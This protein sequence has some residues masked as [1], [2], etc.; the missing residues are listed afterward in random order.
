MAPRGHFTTGSLSAFLFLGI[1]RGTF[2]VVMYCAV[3]SYNSPSLVF[4]LRTPGTVA[5]YIVYMTFLSSTNSEH[6]EN[7][8]NNFKSVRNLWKFAV[9]GFVQLAAPYIL[10]MYGLKVLNPITAGVFM[11]AAPWFSILLE[12]LPCGRST[13]QVSASK[14]GA[15]VIGSI[16]I[17]LVSA[18]GIGL[19]V[20][21]PKSCLPNGTTV[22]M[23][24][25]DNTTVSPSVNEENM[26]KCTPF[27]AVELAGSLLAL[28]GGSVMWSMS[29]IFWRSKR[30]NIHYV[31]GG[32]GNNI[33]G[34]I[35]ALGFFFIMQKHEDYD[36]INW[37]DG[38]AVFSIIFLTLISGWLAALLVDYMMNEVG[39]VVTN[40]VLCMV[41]IV[42][43]F[44][45]WIF[46]REFKMLDVGY[47]I[48]EVVGIVLVLVGL[49]I[50]SLEPENL[51][52][53][54]G[55]PLLSDK[56]QSWDS[57]QFYENV[58][59]VDDGTTS[60]EEVRTPNYLQQSKSFPPLVKITDQDH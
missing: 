32:I 55:R 24:I 23:N 50:S 57:T 11:T 39:A 1:I 35:F 44:E 10:F 20:K 8:R 12:R 14:L 33:F 48:S 18:S 36:Q 27:S 25:S 52:S 29:S 56:E 60:D 46:V 59:I 3:H 2:P 34:G 38:K 26:S 15:I 5:L 28:L 53:V 43:W 21:N 42:V 30:G 54:L 22:P 37:G 19:A 41:P 45:D 47:I 40:R 4:L 9:M 17:I 6:R 16:G 31:S 58:R 7:F 49:T 51:P 13:Y